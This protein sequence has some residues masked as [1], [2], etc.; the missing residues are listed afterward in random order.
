MKIIRYLDAG[1]NEHYGAQAGDG[2]AIELAGAPFSQLKATNRPALVSKLL[3]PLVPVQIFGIGLN[4]RR[5]AEEAEVKF[6]EFPVLFVK[7]LNTL[8]HPGDP[9]LYSY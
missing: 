4:Y 1:G 6:P 8:Q 2:T 7:G 5:H 3:A 9:I